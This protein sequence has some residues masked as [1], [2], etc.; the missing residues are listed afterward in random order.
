FT[1]I[2]PY[3]EE[4]VPLTQIARMHG[5][6][7]RTAR[8]WVHHYREY[9]LSGLV[10]HGRRDHGVHHFPSELVQLIEGLA[11]RKP[12]PSATTIHRQVTEIAKEHNWPVPSYS[13]VYGLIRQLDPGL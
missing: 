1:L 12:P 10:R 5:I 11:L 9:G 6:P 7:L 2:R 3:F 4:G 8:R 13:T